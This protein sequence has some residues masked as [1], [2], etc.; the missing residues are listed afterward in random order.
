MKHARSLLALWAGKLAMGA[1]R[2]LGRGGSSFPGGL[3]RAVDPGILRWLAAQP[4]GGNAVVTGTNGKTMTAKMLSTILAAAG[5]RVVHNRAGANLIGGITAAFMAHASLWGAAGGDVGLLEVD[6]ATM[7]LA[8]AEVR[9]RVA[10]VT[11]FFRDQLDRYGELVTTV[12]YV[13]GGLSQLAPGGT[14][15]LNADDPLCAA[16]GAA[17]EPEAATALEAG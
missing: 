15:C 17:P 4:P 5:R 3:A 16:L 6:E 11:N 9:P 10:V 14:V 8:A 1:A 12:R 2:A 7:P 13:R